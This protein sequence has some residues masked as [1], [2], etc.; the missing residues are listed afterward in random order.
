MSNLNKFCALLTPVTNNERKE[1]LI[2]L[3]QCMDVLSLQSVKPG[4]TSIVKHMLDTNEARSI[5]QSL[6]HIT[7]PLLEQVNRHVEEMIR[8]EVMKPSKSPWALPTA[9][10]KRNSESLRLCIDDREPKPVTKD[11]FPLSYVNGSLDSLRESK[12]FYTLTLEPGHRQVEMVERGRDKLILILPNGLYEIQT[13]SFGACI[14][15]GNA[16]NLMRTAIIGLFPKYC[17]TLG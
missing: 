7:L 1:S 14:G 16:S 2:V 17:K 10:V 15:S 13:F 6:G 12:W 11:A 5:W 9:L 4:R 3:V 8:D